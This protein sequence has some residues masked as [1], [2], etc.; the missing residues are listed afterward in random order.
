MQPTQ[1]VTQAGAQ[2]KEGTMTEQQML[3]YLGAGRERMEAATVFCE[4]CHNWQLKASHTH[5]EAK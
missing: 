5:K 2:H 4:T 1:L 3:D